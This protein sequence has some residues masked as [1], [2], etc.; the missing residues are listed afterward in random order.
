VAASWQQSRGRGALADNDVTVKILE[1]SI[2]DPRIDVQLAWMGA[3]KCDIIPKSA[4]LMESIHKD[5]LIDA[6]P[7]PSWRV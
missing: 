5:C 1:H 2:S 4:G 3:R 6:S 7:N